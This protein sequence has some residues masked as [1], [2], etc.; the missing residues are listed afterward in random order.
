[1]MGWDEN[2]IPLD[3]KLEELELG[4]TKHSTPLPIP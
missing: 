4:W 1:M 3:S 2:G